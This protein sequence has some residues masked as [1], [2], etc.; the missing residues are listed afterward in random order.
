[1]TKITNEDLARMI[2][3]GFEQTASKADLESVEER[4]GDRITGLDGRLGRVESRL[5]RMDDRL[6]HM[7]ARMAR[8]EQ[9][10]AEI[11]GNIVYRHEFEDAL[12]RI[13]YIETKLVSTPLRVARK[14][15]WTRS[16]L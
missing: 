6:G 7:D 9:D 5:D 8:M 1:M 3:K 13:K 2:A 11:R 12:A 16:G 10:I 4:L 14:D 15:P